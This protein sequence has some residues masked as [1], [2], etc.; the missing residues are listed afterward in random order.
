MKISQIS[1]NPKLTSILIVGICLLG[2]LIGNYVERYRISN[3]RW[4]YEYGKLINF[5]MVFGSLGWSF[6]HPLVVWSYNK[7][8]WKKH[9]IWILVGLIPLIYFITM[10]IIAEIRFGNKIT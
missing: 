4:V 7:P 10:M 8:K 2:M 3:Y 1:Y 6:F 9:L 5:I